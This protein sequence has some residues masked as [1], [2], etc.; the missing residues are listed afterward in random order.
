MIIQDV[1]L[2]IY[3]DFLKETDRN[4]RGIMNNSVRK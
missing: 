2:E 4:M 1:K 3:Y